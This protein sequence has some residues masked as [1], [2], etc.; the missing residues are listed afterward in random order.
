MEKL[1]QKFHKLNVS[2]EYRATEVLKEPCQ[3]SKMD[4]LATIVNG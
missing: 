2:V 4:R 3:I 1:T